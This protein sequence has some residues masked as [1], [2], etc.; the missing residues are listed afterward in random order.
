MYVCCPFNVFLSDSPECKAHY[1]ACLCLSGENHV[2]I[3]DSRP[4]AYCLGNQKCF[5]QY[6]PIHSFMWTIRRM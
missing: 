5:S 2:I 1:Y 4:F 3:H 6:N